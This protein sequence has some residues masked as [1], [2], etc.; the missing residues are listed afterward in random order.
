MEFCR[1]DLSTFLRVSIIQSFVYV[2]MG[3]YLFYP[4]GYTTILLY[5]V[6]QIVPALALGTVSI[7]SCV[8][9]LH[10]HHTEGAGVSYLYT[11]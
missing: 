5:F 9:L 3:S 11:L 2:S 8:P 7:G 1:G 6:D 10:T 4:L